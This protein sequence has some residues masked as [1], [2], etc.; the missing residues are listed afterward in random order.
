MWAKARP[1]AN[2]DML[3]IGLWSYGAKVQAKLTRAYS[4]SEVYAMF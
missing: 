4:T 1:S 2:S 3:L